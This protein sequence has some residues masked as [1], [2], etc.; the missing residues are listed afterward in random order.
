MSLALSIL[1]ETYYG[2]C[3][4]NK[5]ERVGNRMNSRCIPVAGLL[6]ASAWLT[7]TAWAEA[8]VPRT[9]DR[10]IRRSVPIP[11]SVSRAYGDST[12]R[13]DG[14][15]GS[16]YWQLEVNYLIHATLD[17]T[18]SV[19]SGRETAVVHNAS[20]A[21]LDEMRMRFDQNL[22][23]EEAPRTM[24]VPEYT[25]GMVVTALSIDGIASTLPGTETN[26]RFP[27]PEPL[28]PNDS[29]T[30]EVEWHFRVP[31]DERSTA[32]RLGR[33]ADSVYQVAQW[34]PRVAVYDDLMGWD[35]ASY[36]GAV[37]F[38]NNFGRFEVF[39]DVPAGWLVGATGELQNPEA[40][41]SSQ[42]LDA[43]RE[44]RASGRSALIARASG[45]QDAALSRPDRAIW[46][47]VADTV[48]DFA[49][50]AS[51]RYE[52][53]TAWAD[54]PGQGSIPVHAFQT[55]SDAVEYPSAADN[56]ARYIQVF[57]QRLIPSLS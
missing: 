2:V 26:Q 55:A 42:V 18:T 11:R 3:P 9:D 15:P 32:V 29:S 34:Y 46:H 25:D 36:H 8:D 28:A 47:F 23:R 7:I 1:V 5:K 12:R 24:V 43:L 33:W 57:S 38:Y 30:I 37:E 14:N 50:A 39:L 45:R 10:E 16:R 40:V 22:F 51:D 49:W 52:W 48:S 54:I 21:P 13:P 53:R 31:L 56:V 17:P 27:L 44:S 20:D 19:V 4:A 41:L 35:T 6:V